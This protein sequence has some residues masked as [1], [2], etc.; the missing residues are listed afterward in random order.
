MAG[1]KAEQGSLALGEGRWIA[2]RRGLPNPR[3]VLGGLLV[4]GAGLATF[5]AYSDASGAPAT[6][7]VVAARDLRPGR[8]LQPADLATVRLDLGD[9]LSGHL[10][11]DPSELVD[12]QVVAPISR[13][14]LLQASSVTEQ[15]SP[16]PGSEVAL[17]VPRANVAVGRLELGDRIDVYA[18]SDAGTDP[19]ARGLLVVD[20]SEGAAGTARDDV[21]VVVIVPELG[22]VNAVVD[23]LRGADVTLV[24]S[25]FDRVVPGGDRSAGRPDPGVEQ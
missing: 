14:E 17:V 9:A 5:A 21:E 18:T 25:T 6:T 16:A 2:R 11:R 15:D 7:Y 4:T 12:H 1:S 23:A 20:L 24:R 10:Y 19:I 22:T 8:A 3:A 13:G